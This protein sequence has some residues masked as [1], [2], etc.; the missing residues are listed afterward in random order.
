M[1]LII[2]RDTNIKS[3]L[4]SCSA[5]WWKNTSRRLALIPWISS[6]HLFKHRLCL[7]RQSPSWTRCVT[8]RGGSV[9]LLFILTM[10][11]GLGCCRIH[12]DITERH[13]NVSLFRCWTNNYISFQHDAGILLHEFFLRDKTLQHHSIITR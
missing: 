1:K 11:Q 12:S 10:L 6:K 5:L 3:V 13:H 7:G 4:F 8:H 9:F 2:L